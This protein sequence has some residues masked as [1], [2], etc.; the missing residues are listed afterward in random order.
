MADVG[1]RRPVYLNLARSV[2]TDLLIHA[3]AYAGDLHFI[4]T[5][6]SFKFVRY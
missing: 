2:L 5:G 4:R 6:S 1:D 3:V